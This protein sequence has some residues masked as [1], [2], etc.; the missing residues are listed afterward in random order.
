M[1]HHYCSEEHLFR[2]IT[3]YDERER[4]DVY[5]DIVA[6]KS[7]Y[8]G[9]FAQGHRD[10]Y[11]RKRVWVEARMYRDF[12]VEYWK[13]KYTSPVYFYLY[14]HFSLQ[15]IENRLKNRQD[16]EPRT[17][18]LL[19]DLKDL[20]D[21]RHISFTV[22]DS[23]TSYRKLLEEEGAVDRDAPV[24]KGYADHGRV[25]HI[26]EIDR[27]ISEYPDDADLYFEVQVWDKDVLH[28]WIRKKETEG[29]RPMG[30]PGAPLTRS[31]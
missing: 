24:P 9:R 27:L 4:E 11:M 15:L 17:R 21:T 26:Q 2:T 7:W 22:S 30:V 13:P 29:S 19:V 16:Y 1:V 20:D 31:A 14:P 12:S 25:F 5:R 8:W 3:M 18:Y 28:A 10:A 6:N 23:L